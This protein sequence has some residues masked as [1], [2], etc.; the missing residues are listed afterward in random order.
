MELHPGTPV[1]VNTP[2]VPASKFSFSGVV[3]LHGVA[4]AVA[5]F[6]R[7][8]VGVLVGGVPV[9]VGGTSERAIVSA[10]LIWSSPHP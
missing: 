5:V 6:V 3:R 7:V 1:V 4:V 10:L 9:T 8:L 2:S